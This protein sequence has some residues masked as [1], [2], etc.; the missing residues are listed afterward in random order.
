MTKLLSPNG[1]TMHR[2]DAQSS[3]P[4]AISPSSKPFVLVPL[5]FPAIICYLLVNSF[6]DLRGHRCPKSVWITALE[7]LSCFS[8]CWEQQNF[9]D[10]LTTFSLT[11]W[12]NKEDWYQ[13]LLDNCAGRSFRGCT[14]ALLYLSTVE[15]SDPQEVI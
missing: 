14:L 3:L 7:V 12:H 1:S 13:G 5:L 6:C 2:H 11:K 8:I 15:L 9:S 10:P 4:N